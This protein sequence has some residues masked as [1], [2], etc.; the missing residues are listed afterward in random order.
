MTEFLPCSVFGA[1]LG[2]VK[3][4]RRKLSVPDVSVRFDNVKFVPMTG[5][6]ASTLVV[7]PPHVYVYGGPPDS[8]HATLHLS[9]TICRPLVVSVSS[10]ELVVAD[11]VSVML[12]RA[13]LPVFLTSTAR[14]MLSPAAM[15]LAPMLRRLLVPLTLIA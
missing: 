13:M 11:V 7:V 4:T 8:V 15:L 5:A 2:R 12:A 1:A 14:W 10:N 6:V 3:V 9:M